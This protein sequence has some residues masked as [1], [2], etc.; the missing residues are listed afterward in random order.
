MLPKRIAKRSALKPRATL[1]RTTATAKP[2][3]R[4]TASEASIPVMTTAIREARRRIRCVNTV[5]PELN[6]KCDVAAMS[7]YCCRGMPRAGGRPA[8]AYFCPSRIIF[9][10]RPRMFGRDL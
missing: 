3:D 6:V 10:F 8:C 7:Q 2:P 4:N 5:T 9:A 1:M